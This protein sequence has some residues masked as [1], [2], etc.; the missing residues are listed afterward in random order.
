M[1]IHVEVD[2]VC[3][4]CGKVLDGEMGISGAIRIEPCESCLQA[5]YEEGYEE[6][7]KDE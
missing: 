4:E 1:E 7:K 6:G 3:M 2:V 5:A